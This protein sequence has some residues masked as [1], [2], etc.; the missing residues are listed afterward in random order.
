M[1]NGSEPPRHRLMPL[2]TA[3]LPSWDFNVRFLV[4]SRVVLGRLGSSSFFF[5]VTCRGTVKS[6]FF[7]GG[8]GATVTG[9]RTCECWTIAQKFEDPR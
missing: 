7:F 2:W 9:H 8:D 1:G 6:R 3:Q 4:R 5:R